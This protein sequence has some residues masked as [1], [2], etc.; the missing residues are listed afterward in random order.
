MTQVHSQYPLTRRRFCS[1]A[2][3]SALAVALCGSGCTASGGKPSSTV[4]P[5]ASSSVASA[6]SASPSE[7]GVGWQ[8]RTL[9][10]FDTVVTLRCA[11]AAEVMDRAVDRCAY[12]EEHF[13]RTREGSDVWNINHAGGASVSVAPETAD[14]VEKALGYCERSEGLFDITIGAVSSLWDFKEG[15]KPSDDAIQEAVRH[16]DYRGVHMEGT[17]VTLDDPQAAL[18][19]GGAAKGYVADD[20]ARLFRD[21]GCQSGV[22]NLGGNAYVIGSKP[23]GSPWNVG[24]Q[25]PNAPTNQAVI[26]K[27]A[28]TDASVV[29]SGLYER[30]FM[31]EGVRY[32]HILD[33]KTG[34][35]VQT[36]LVSSSVL[37]ESSLDGDAFATWMFLLGSEAA[38]SLAESISGL[39][40]LFVTDGGEMSMTQGAH[41]EAL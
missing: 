21:G 25:D 35:P 28:C 5:T 8:E 33:P 31:Q 36:D 20:L 2:G 3:A 37:T 23:D 6:S 30:E 22:I 19:L 16:V 27:V 34:Y 13:S 29:T 7:A 32:Y 9:F 15:V 26:A 24:V 1:L 41:F 38:L 4:T 10:A 11:C 39:E 14:L 17:S 18:D 40:A 12:F